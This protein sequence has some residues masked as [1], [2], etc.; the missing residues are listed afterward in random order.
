MISWVTVICQFF[1]K[2]HFKNL[3][4]NLFY[5]GKSIDKQALEAS[6]LTYYRNLSADRTKFSSA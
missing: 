3:N 1:L 4:R 6:H 2:Q 5:L